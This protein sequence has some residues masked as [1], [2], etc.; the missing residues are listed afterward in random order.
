[1]IFVTVGT[2]EQSFDRLIR[3]IDELR[4]KCIIKD[5]V[6]IQTGYSNYAPQ[7]CNY[8]KMI[9]YSEMNEYAEMADIIITHG[10]PGSIMVAWQNNKI[11]IVV[12]R[13]P[14]YNEH[15]DRHQI[16]FTKRLEKLQK[17]IAIYEIERLGFTVNNYKNICSDLNVDFSSNNDNFINKMENIIYNMNIRR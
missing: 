9:G 11:P 6:F 8:K 13:N 3:E 2:H 15:V 4:G 14:E 7:N 12:P 5:E 17:V 10:G 1:M 16:L